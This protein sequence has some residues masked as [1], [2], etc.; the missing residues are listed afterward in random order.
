MN[1]F[2]VFFKLKLKSFDWHISAPDFRNANLKNI[3]KE[4]ERVSLVI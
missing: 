4:K 1:F 2:F 3:L